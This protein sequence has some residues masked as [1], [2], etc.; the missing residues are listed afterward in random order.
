MPG[1]G[2]PPYIPGGGPGLGGMLLF[3]LLKPTLCCKTN[4]QR[5]LETCFCTPP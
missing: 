3:V 1:D 2:L 5:E 4:K